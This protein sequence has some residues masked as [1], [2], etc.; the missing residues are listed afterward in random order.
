MKSNKPRHKK[1]RL[2]TFGVFLICTACGLQIAQIVG[3]KLN[4][5]PIKATPTRQYQVPEDRP[6]IK[7]LNQK[8]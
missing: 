7:D 4:P 5:Q 2:F 6:L 3:D 1:S 8:R